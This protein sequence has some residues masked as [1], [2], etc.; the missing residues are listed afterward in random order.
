MERYDYPRIVSQV[1]ILTTP[2]Y[3][4]NHEL[5]ENPEPTWRAM[6]AL[7]RSGKA[8][9]IGVSN[10]TIPRLEQLLSFATIK[11]AVNQVEIHPFL[12]NQEL[13]DYCQSKDILLVAYSPLGSQNQVPRTGEK[14]AEN[15]TLNEVAQSSGHTLAQTLIAWGIKRGY[16]VLPKSATPSRIQSNFQ[17]YELSEEDYAKV[18]AVAKDRHCR[19]VNMKDT[20]GFDLW[21]EEA[22]N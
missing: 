7:Q 2:Q 19:F 4:I 20:F 16:P 8:R 14:V 18:N 10:W 1:V 9:A 13:L 11:P 3:V 15:K 22:D 6:E 17:D 12:P 21:P 5:T